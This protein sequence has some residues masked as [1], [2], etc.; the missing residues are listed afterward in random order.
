V[1]RS[2]TSYST[3]RG[4]GG[5]LILIILAFLLLALVGAG[6]FLGTRT[7]PAPEAGTEKVIPDERFP[8]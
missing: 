2:R 5:R 7:L 3:S 8:R 4:I 6:V 1:A